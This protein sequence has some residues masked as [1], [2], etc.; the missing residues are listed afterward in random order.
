M[1]RLIVLSGPSGVGK[2]PMVDWMK[3][4]YYP[5]SYKG[6][7]Q[8]FCQVK[9]HKTGT[10]R[11]TGKESELGLEGISENRYDFDCRGS[12]QSIDLDELD[13][14]IDCHDAVLIEAYYKA[15]DFLKDRYES[16]VDFASTF[17]SPL[18]IHEDRSEI[19]DRMLDAL[20]RRALREGKNMTLKLV[21]DLF[22]RAKGSIDEMNIAHK[23][24]NIIVN[25]CYETDPRWHFDKLSGEPRKAVDALY[26][27]VSGQK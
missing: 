5:E 4:I 21:K 27:I 1:K 20:V 3:K 23:Y 12:A 8:A 7:I 10:P 14:A 6:D 26:K 17:V 25:E 18:P 11:H 15:F 2:G 9:V 16:R 19:P 13:K 24:R 22:K